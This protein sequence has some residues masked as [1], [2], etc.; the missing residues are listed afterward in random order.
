MTP[1]PWLILSFLLSPLG[2]FYVDARGV[3]VISLTVA[4]CAVSAALVGAIFSRL[5][6]RYHVHAIV[7]LFLAAF[8]LATNVYFLM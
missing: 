8:L 7:A 5:T 4:S 2:Y 3:D 6:R 1:F